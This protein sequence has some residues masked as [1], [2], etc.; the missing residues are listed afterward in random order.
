VRFSNQ[1]AI[2]TGAASGIGRE[3]A[4]RLAAEGAA[5][6]VADRDLTGAEEV[7]RQL[8]ATGKRVLAVAVDVG[9]VS[10]TQAM[11]E[12]V[13]AK[14][15]PVDVL[16]NCASHP[17]SDDLLGMA[18]EDWD[19]DI[20][21][22]LRGAYL[23]VRSVLPTMIERRRGSIINVASVNAFGF[24]GN[25]AYSAAKAGLISLTRSIA[26]R[27]GRFGVR[28]NAVAPATVRTPMWD[29]RIAADPTVLERAGAWYPLQ[30]VGEPG[31][32]ANAVTFL[33]SEDAGWI[34]GAVLPVDGGLSAGNF[35]MTAAL[36]VESEW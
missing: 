4:Q 8:R 34:T 1:T 27:Y 18:V 7:A 33:A 20:R 35:R 2:V 30:R 16:V 5:V 24:Y 12:R 23:C 32:V 14:L 6:A 17:P 22:S 26:V 19:R 10:Q 9:D 15:G 21:T 11:A 3:I 31:D 36:V 13:D 25:E 28:A 29:A